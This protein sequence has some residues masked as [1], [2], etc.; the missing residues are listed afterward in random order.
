MIMIMIF[1]HSKCI[2][3]KYADKICHIYAPHI[4]PNSAYFPHILLPKVVHIL[5]KIINCKPTSLLYILAACSVSVL[6]PSTLD[7]ITF[8]KSEF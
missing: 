6:A 1:R 3:W 2:C 8:S 4:S 7:L 5:K